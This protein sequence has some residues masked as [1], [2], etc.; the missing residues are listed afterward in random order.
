MTVSLNDDARVPEALDFLELVGEQEDSCEAETDEL[1]TTLGKKAPACLEQIGTALSLL[2]RLA[3]CWWGCRRGDHVIEYLCG[4]VASNARAAL[5]LMRF[6]FYD[7]SLLLCRAMGETANMLELFAMDNGAYEEWRAASRAY[8][9]SA[10][11]PVKIRLQLEALDEL[12]IIAEERYRALSER[13][14]HVQPETKP[15]SHNILG[16]PG[17]GA[18]L[19]EEGVLVCLNEIAIPLAAT[20]IFGTAKLGVNPETRAKTM[21]GAMA[22]AE[23]IGSATVTSIDDYHRHVLEDPAARDALGHVADLVRRQQAGRD[24]A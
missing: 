8:R 21:A 16:L 1:L 13:S 18:V 23:Q 12:P 20:V 3:S 7:E 17:S 2:D 19:Q 24:R 22:L 5:R 6:G 14:A 9:M 15:Q 11:S 10:F 4:R